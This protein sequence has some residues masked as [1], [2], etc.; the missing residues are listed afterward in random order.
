M[1]SKI[2]KTRKTCLISSLFT[3]Q[4]NTKNTK[5]RKQEQFSENTQIIFAVLSKTVLNDSFQKQKPN[6][7]KISSAAV[8]T[9]L[10]SV[11]CHHFPH[12]SMRDP[13][14]GSLQNHIVCLTIKCKKFYLFLKFSVLTSVH[15]YRDVRETGKNKFGP[16]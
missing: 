15:I 1:F 5:S 3:V 11:A 6:M 2:R 13:H 8:L 10:F 4:K 14:C 12:S 16:L 7:P 9:L